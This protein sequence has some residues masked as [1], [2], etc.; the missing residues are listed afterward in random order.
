MKEML[1][2]RSRYQDDSIIGHLMVFDVKPNGSSS[3]VFECKTLELQYKNNQRNVSAVPAGYY[4]IVLEHSPRFKMDLWELKGV[5]GRSEAKIHVANF[6][7]QL[8]GCIGVGDLHLNLDNDKNLDV[9]NSRDTLDRLHKAMGKE[10]KA[11]I[12]IIGRT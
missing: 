6:Y 1:L 2:Y 11:T 10:K 3:L 4:N 9:R 8:N 7:R 5:P 12:K